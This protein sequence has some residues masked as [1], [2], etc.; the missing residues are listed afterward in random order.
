MLD[1]LLSTKLNIPQVSQKM[2]HRPRLIEQMNGGFRGDDS[3]FARKLTLVSAPAGY[4]KTT[5]AAEWLAE[6]AADNSAHYL[7]WL[8]LGATDNDFA[9]F[10][11]Y[12]ILALQ[13]ID[14]AIGAEIQ[15]ILESDTDLP[16]EPLVTTLVN[17]IAA[18]GAACRPGQRCVLVLDDYYLITEFSIHTALDFLIDHLPSCMQLVI[19]TR[20]DPPIPLGR[21]RVQRALLEIREV[22]L[23]FT[24]DE[25]TTFLNSLM[26]LDLAAT[27]IS[28]LEA[29]TEG[30]IAGLQLAALTLQCRAD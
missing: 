3:N 5:L 27:D 23:Q 10:F 6:L 7:T 29:R 13:Q 17:D 1:S 25:A 16:T 15:P 11:S 19:I 14:T 28:A 8:S 30:W 4:G 9:R 20:V 21:L 12:L 2:V 26:G 22:D 24:T 18:W